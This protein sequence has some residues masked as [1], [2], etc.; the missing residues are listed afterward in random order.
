MSTRP[1]DRDE[2]RLLQT[3]SDSAV[4]EKGW[5]RR[6]VGGWRFTDEIAG[7]P[8]IAS[9]MR[10]LAGLGYIQRDDV[11]DPV[12]AAPLYLHRVTLRGEDYLGAAGGRIL[13]T[14]VQPGELT[15]ADLDSVFLS[16][17]AWD[18]LAALTEVEAGEGWRLAAKVGER[19]GSSFLRDS[20]QA[21]VARRL[22]EMRT[23]PDELGATRG[24]LQYRATRLG[25]GARLLDGRASE[26]R[27]QVRVPGIKLKAPFQ[28]RPRG[29]TS[30]G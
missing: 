4:E 7:F 13:R 29:L 24:A 3:L 16:R 27:V 2:T 12:R 8:L 30:G 14:I 25:R 17:D 9:Q 21:L 18:G 26:S 28:S 22:A 20:G 15:A 1:L 11:L 6:S 23:A 19:M 10:Y 5:T